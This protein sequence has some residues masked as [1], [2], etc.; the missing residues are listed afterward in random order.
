M[1]P[2]PSFWRRRLN[3]IPYWRTIIASTPAGRC[4]Q[5]LLSGI[6]PWRPASSKR[7]IG[8]RLW[9]PRA[10]LEFYQAKSRLVGGAGGIRTL[11]TLLAYTHFPGE[12][13]RPLGHRSACSGVAASSGSDGRWQASRRHANG[14]MARRRSIAAPPRQRSGRARQNDRRPPLRRQSLSTLS[15]STSPGSPGQARAVKPISRSSSI[16]AWLSRL[17]LHCSFLTPRAFA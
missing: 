7:T 17:S 12:R 5:R 13:L 9:E 16:A 8:E 3:A 6:V 2:V 4:G 10:F 15:T 1:C 11:D 14:R